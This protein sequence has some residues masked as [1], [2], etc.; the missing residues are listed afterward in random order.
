MY[1]M[2]TYMF[3]VNVGKYTIHGCVMGFFFHDSRLKDCRYFHVDRTTIGEKR[4][5][6]VAEATRRKNLCAAVKMLFMR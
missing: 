5:M 3:M 2:F 4:N 1:G 6:A